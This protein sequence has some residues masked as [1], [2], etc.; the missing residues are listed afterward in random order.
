MRHARL[1][2]AVL[3]LVLVGTGQS[4][5]TD[6]LIGGKSL[7]IEARNPTRRTFAFRSTVESGIGSPFVDP[8]AGTGATLRVFVSNAAGQCSAEAD[9][10]PVYWTPIGG[11]GAAKG[12]R[13]RDQ[14]GSQ[15]GI[16]SVKFQRRKNGGQIKVKARGA[17]PCG[18]ESP[19]QGP[20]HVEL[21]VNGTRYCAEFGGNVAKNGTGSFRASDAPPPLAC[22]PNGVTVA[23]LNV[24]HGIFCP[25]ETNGCRRADRIE[26]LRQFVVDR[27]CPDVLAF[28]EVFSLAASNENADALL[29]AI[30][31]TCPEP[32]F[33]AYHGENPF[34]DEMIFSRYPILAQETHHLLGPLRNVLRVRID[35]PIG[36]LD[37]YATHLASGSDLAT[38]PCA[39]TF[40]PCP[41]ECIA[42]GA[43]T[44]RQCQAVQM[45]QYIDATHDVQAP[46]LAVGDFNEEPSTF[47]YNQFASRGWIDSHLAAGLPECDA[48]TGIGC[49]SGR[50]DDALTDL[51]NPAFNVGERIDYIWLIPSGPASFCSAQVEPT[52]DPDLDGVAT[53][54]FADVPNPF[55]PTCGPAPDP[56]CWSSDHTGNQAD[57]NC[58]F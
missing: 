32:Y 39:G 10:F 9:L 51:E 18:L 28:Q 40:G 20:V 12:W 53:R 21:R 47:V 5:A 41:P 44:V 54:L 11:D 2:V 8:T 30:T 56:I 1:A 43:A 6:V 35:H 25:P 31:N 24:L 46:A 33:A 38:N 57:V 29:Q 17:F 36:P 4:Q 42:T 7:R 58:I 52:G 19:Q 50:I 16:Q 26:L 23:S 14:S 13:Y 15:L 45:A 3:A 27:G 55:S 49:T 37:V 34:D 22:L 48:M